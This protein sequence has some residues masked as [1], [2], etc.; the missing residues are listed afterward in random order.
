MPGI[1]SAL[2][3][4]FKFHREPDGEETEL[5]FLCS[6]ALVL[7]IPNAARLNTVPH[8]VVTPHPETVDIFFATP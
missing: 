2:G 8:V 4:W 5:F 6:K 1:S 3:L 7:T